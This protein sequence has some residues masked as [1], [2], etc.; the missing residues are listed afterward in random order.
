MILDLCS[1]RFFYVWG[2]KIIVLLFCV[3]IISSAASLLSVYCSIKRQ[4]IIREIAEAKISQQMCVQ[5][6]PAL[7]F[8]D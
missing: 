1:E 3:G 7:E 5:T 4:T 2:W 6:P 8:M